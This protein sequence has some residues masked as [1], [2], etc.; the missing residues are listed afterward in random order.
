M[1]VLLRQGFCKAV[2]LHSRLVGVGVW[3][4]GRS[5]RPQTPT[6][7]NCQLAKNLVQGP[8]QGPTIMIRRV[9]RTC[10]GAH[11]H[12][13]LA[14]SPIFSG[15]RDTLRSTV[16]ASPCGCPRNRYNSLMSTGSDPLP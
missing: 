1:T 10:I 9:E 15:A 3:G 4:R 12:S 16:V 13:S 6:P 2:L 7:T 8:F 14:R 11:A 5:S